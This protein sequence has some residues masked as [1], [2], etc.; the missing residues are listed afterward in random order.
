MIGVRREDKNRWERRAPITP[1]HVAELA[2]HG[3]TV[4]CEPSTV[5]VFPDGAFRDAGA[6]I[7]GDLSSCPLVIGVKEIPAAK[8]K[9]GK[10]YAFFAH[11]AKGQPSNMPML[12]RM[13]ELGCTLIDYEKIV[14]DRGRRLVFFGRHAGFAGM[15]DTLTALGR[16]LLW[17]GIASPFSTMKMAHEYAD[18]EEAHADLARVAD[19]VRRGGVPAQLHPL[20]FGFTGSGNVAKGAQEIFDHLPY[21]EILPEDLAAATADPDLPRNILYKVAFSRDERM[22]QDGSMR[23]HLSHLTVLV[24]GVYWEP[25]H[26]RVVSFDD[27]RAL[28][29]GASPRLRVIADISCDVNGSIE[30][31]VRVTTP[32]NPIYV[33]DVARGEAVDGVAGAGPVILAVDNLPCELPVDASRSFGD[34]LLRFLPALAR[35]D[36]TLPFESLPLP[37]DVRRAVIVHRGKLTPAFAYLGRHLR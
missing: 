12:A 28:F 3:V 6:N 1:E 19:A 31:N 13:M 4:C 11:V 5:R 16:R 8:L 14:D 2:R 35:C 9:P 37:D 34:A 24:N 27:L 7:D 33:Y 10:A 17:E 15:L 26:P 30:A 29:H 21:E 23:R 25:Q 22:A 20:V 36:W 18:L 32:D